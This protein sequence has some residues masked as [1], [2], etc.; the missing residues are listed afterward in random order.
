MT[1]T[2]HHPLQSTQP[3][4]EPAEAPPQQHH[5]PVSTATKVLLFVVA[6]II[7]IAVAAAMIVALWPTPVHLDFSAAGASRATVAVPDARIELVPSGDGE[8]HVEVTGWYSGTEPDFTVRTEEDE[9]EVRGG[10]RVIVLSRCSLTVAVALPATADVRIAG[11]N[12]NITASEMTGSLDIG[13]T[14]GALRVTD[15]IGVLNL[16]ATNGSIQVL[17][18]Q[19]PEISAVTTNGQVELDFATA[20]TEVLARSTN[21]GITVR[22]PGGEP[23]FLDIRTTN[24]ALNRDFESDRFADRTITAETTNG[25]ISVERSGG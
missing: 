14:N 15:A 11:T 24:G 18:A 10:C 4:A 17:G 7:V 5:R 12:G 22:V 13:T 6:P 20:P 1:A 2:P 21:G 25:S 19:S 8:V 3:P 16:R 9:T 23:Y